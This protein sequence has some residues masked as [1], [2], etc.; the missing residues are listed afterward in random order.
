MIGELTRY[1]IIVASLL[2]TS[3]VSG[4]EP[5]V[6]QDAPPD[7]YLSVII[8]GDIMQHGP[9][10][11]A[12]WVDS[13]QSYDYTS[14]FQY[15]APIVSKADIAI[16]NLEVT[17]A[18]PP[19][20]GY[21]QFSAPDQ[22]A[23]AVKQ[24]GFD[25]LVTANNHSCDR[26]DDGLLRTIRVLDSV[27]MK[28]TGTFA[29]NSDYRQHHP[30][31]INQNDITLALLNY[32]Y[33]TNG[34]P[35]NYPTMVNLI[36]EQTV[37]DDL[38]YTRSLEPDF[39]VVYFHWG[40]EYETQ[41]TDLQRNLAQISKD[42]GADAVIGSHPHVLQPMEYHPEN[43]SIHK[44]HL[45][46]YSL[47]NYVSN[48]RNRLRDGGAMISFT[49]MKTWEHKTIV[50]PQ[51]HLTWVYNPIEEGKRQYYILPVNMPDPPNATDDEAMEKMTRFTQDSRELLNAGDN[52]VPEAAL[53]PVEE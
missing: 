6:S 51:Y 36:D 11:T 41:P 35:F 19:Y 52:S 29:D 18:G 50:D 25:V 7:K 17:L 53:E 30:L 34:L 16:A 8:A 24:A 45:V 22:L 40:N 2:I 46:V 42:H 28:R 21:P 32:T 10:I 5:T 26:G 14:C 27:G 4:P 33:G 48:Q 3:H 12:A 1:T 15:I 37:I 13:N 31:I 9:Q 43:D 23:V 38:T 20:T 49:L 44:S 47:G 39:I